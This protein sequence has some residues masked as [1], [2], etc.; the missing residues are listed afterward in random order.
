MSRALISVSNKRGVVQFAKDLVA[1]KWEIVSTGGT[2]EALQREG[3][4]EGRE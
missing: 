1:L 2:A 4:P 3:V